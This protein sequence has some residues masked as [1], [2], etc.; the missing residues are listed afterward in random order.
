[1]MDPIKTS[2]KV[3]FDVIY[4]DGRRARVSDGVLFE[5]DGNQVNI[6]VGTDRREGMLF[7]IAWATTMFI[8][9]MGLNEAFSKFLNILEDEY[10]KANQ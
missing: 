2:A 3:E 9:Q 4:A 5:A 10:G 8:K 7:T 6:H 1:M